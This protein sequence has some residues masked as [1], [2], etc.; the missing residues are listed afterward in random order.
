MNEGND[1]LDKKVELNLWTSIWTKPREA[2]RYAIDHKSMKFAIILAL[3]AGIFNMLNGAS[4]NN[5]GDTMSIPSIFVLGFVLGPILGWISWW[6]SAGLA[7]IVGSWL[8]GT[9]RFA[10]LKMALAVSYIP[11]ILVGVLWIPDLL[12]LGKILFVESSYISIGQQIWLFI[13]G[14]ISIVVGIWIFVI[15]IMAISEA[16]RFSA[17]RGF[18]TIVIPSVVVIIVLLLFLVPFIFFQ[19]L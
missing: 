7:K 19:F 5:L 18:W 2:V 13:S 3:I 4:S 11:L 12:I 16:H 15:T 6:I 14:I 10:E 1:V 9:G 8:G 17:W